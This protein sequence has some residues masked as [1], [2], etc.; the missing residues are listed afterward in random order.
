MAPN[1]MK[2]KNQALIVNVA[3]LAGLGFQY[4]RGAPILAILIAGI[5]LLLIVNVIFFVRL[6]KSKSAP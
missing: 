3:I 6:R 1:K 2:L 5:L 4:F